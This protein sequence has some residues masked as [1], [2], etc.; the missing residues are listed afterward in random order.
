MT[1]PESPRPERDPLA[2]AGRPFSV[3]RALAWAIFLVAAAGLAFHVVFYFAGP[4]EWLTAYAKG[5]GIWVGMGLAFATLLATHL[6]YWRTRMR[7]D[8]AS[9]VLAYLW[10]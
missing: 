1:V 10:I 2:P 3:M 5:T 6:H 7:L 8:I 4:S 9:R